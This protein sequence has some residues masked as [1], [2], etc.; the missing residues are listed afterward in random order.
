MST[1]PILIGSFLGQVGQNNDLVDLTVPHWE[2]CGM[3][4]TVRYT[5]SKSVV[6]SILFGTR[7]EKD[8]VLFSPFLRPPTFTLSP[9]K[10]PD[11][12]L[13]LK[14]PWS[15]RCKCFIQRRGKSAKRVSNSGKHVLSQSM[16]FKVRWYLDF[17]SH[18]GKGK[19]YS[20][21][22]GRVNPPKQLLGCQIQG[23]P[24]TLYFNYH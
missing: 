4:C 21:R 19:N 16:N 2:Y 23:L 3:R 11:S 12:M 9:K 13:E 18:P 15:S 1:F 5:T 20:V 22:S 14:L 7:G 10:K 24:S 17:P 6:T 8:A